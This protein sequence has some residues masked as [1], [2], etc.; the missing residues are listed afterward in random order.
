M[1]FTSRWISIAACVLLTLLAGTTESSAQLVASGRTNTVIIGIKPAVLSIDAVVATHS[2]G[3]ILRRGESGG[4]KVSVTNTGG[5]AAHSVIIEPQQPPG[6]PRLDFTRLTALG[7]IDAGETKTEEIRIH[8]LDD[9]PVLD[10]SLRLSCTGAEGVKVDTDPFA[11]K[12]RPSSVRNDNAGPIIDVFDESAIASRSIRPVR[13]E[14]HLTTSRSAFHLTGLVRDSSGVAKVLVGGKEIGLQWTSG[15]YQIDRDVPLSDGDNAIDISAF[16]KFGNRTVVTLR[17]TRDA[18]L[19]E[20]RFFALLIGVKDYDDP[21]ITSLQR[22]IEDIERLAAVLKENYMFDAT[23]VVVLRNPDRERILSEMLALR[24][25]LGEKDNLLI[26]Y[27]GHGV[28]DKAAKMGYWLPSNADL[29]QKSNWLSNSDLRAEIRAMKTRHTLLV[30]DACFSG[31]LFVTRSISREVTAQ[32]LYERQSRRGITSGN[33]TVPEPSVFLE[34]IIRQLRA[35]KERYLPAQD[36]F[37]RLK[38]NVTMNSPL[39]Q[40]PSYGVISDAGDVGNGDF[41]FVRR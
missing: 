35:N 9:T 11:V 22:P 18:S 39:K 15:G 20:G 26:Y 30:A 4:I 36:L 21:K 29:T 3:S 1:A 14:R 32:M 16:D 13:L 25:R 6:A 19:I 8:A 7:D 12:I 40:V 17:V 33:E 24:G 38:D 41:I 34:E 28:E 27:A 10:L 2:A 5:V 23:S 31:S 37:S